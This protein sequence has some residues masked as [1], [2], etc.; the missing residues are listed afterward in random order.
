MVFVVKL[1]NFRLILGVTHLEAINFNF[2][3]YL[4]LFVLVLLSNKSNLPL[5]H[6]FPLKN[7]F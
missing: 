3:F 4:P 6:R 1:Q 2:Y 7:K 5:G